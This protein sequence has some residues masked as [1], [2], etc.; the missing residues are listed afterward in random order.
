LALVLF[1]AGISML[2][3]G[4]MQRVAADNLVS[5]AVTVPA[6]IPSTPPIITIPSDGDTIRSTDTMAAG[7]C[8]LITPQAVIGL[9]LDDK[10][11]GTASCDA[12]NNFSFPLHL[13]AGNHTLA[14]SAYTFTGGV[15]LTSDPITLTVNPVVRTGAAAATDPPHFEPDSI[16]VNLDA[17]STATWSGTVYGADPSYTLDIDWGD[18][19]QERQTVNPGSQEFSHRYTTFASYNVAFTLSNATASYT[20]QYAV[21]SYTAATPSA[22]NLGTARPASGSTTLGLY[23]LFVTVVAVV[24]IVRL[25]AA[26]FAFTNITLYHHRHAHS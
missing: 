25:H 6:P 24:G 9:V 3:I 22:N 15:G 18:G 7:S 20:Q 21:A 13:T 4:I 2:G 14:A 19:N 5:I 11:I 10:A 16:F 8:P 23:G 26:P 1:V 17:N 12:N